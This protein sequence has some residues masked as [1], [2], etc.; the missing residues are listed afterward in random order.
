MS[1]LQR[2]HFR[3]LIYE[4]GKEELFLQSWTKLH[5]LGALFEGK[6]SISESLLRHEGKHV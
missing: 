5:S 3:K 1:W 2:E 4:T 6:H